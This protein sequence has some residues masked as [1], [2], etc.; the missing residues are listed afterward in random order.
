MV[1]EAIGA[2]AGLY[3]AID[4]AVSRILD[5][6]RSSKPDNPPPSPFPPIRVPEHRTV[7]G[8]EDEFR[9]LRTQLETCRGSVI[10]AKGAVLQGE[11]GYGKTTLA[12]YFAERTRE[13]YEG[14]CWVGAETREQLFK[15]VMA[16]GAVS[17]GFAVPEQIRDVDVEAVIH[18]I[19]KSGARLLFVFDN[20]DDFAMVR[21]FLPQS[22]TVDVILTSR[23]AGDIPGFSAFALDVLDAEGPNSPAVELLLQEAAQPL[24]QEREDAMALAK[25]L[26]G[27]P[28]ALVIAG[29]IVRNGESFAE[30]RADISRLIETDPDRKELYRDGVARA[31][32]ASFKKLSVEAQWAANAC[33]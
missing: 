24:A 23:E 31:V 16:F 7:I 30:V 6:R 33:A 4:Q 17:F 12:R 10:T 27:L 14:G 28:L 19:D 9:R 21:A 13:R 15:N 3:S 18:G 25:E 29:A 22:E 26:G 11:G 20:A 32:L 2:G 1:F 8:R 5:A